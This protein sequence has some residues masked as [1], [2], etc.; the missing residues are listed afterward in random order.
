MI[1]DFMIRSA[2]YCP[3]LVLTESTDTVEELHGIQGLPPDTYWLSFGQ[4]K[5]AKV[6]HTQLHLK[7]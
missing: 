5:S 3:E 1:L 6:I 7:K 4:V 2:Y